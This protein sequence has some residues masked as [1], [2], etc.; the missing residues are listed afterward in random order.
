MTSINRAGATFACD[1]I[2]SIFG[3]NHFT[4]DITADCIS[5]NHSLD[6]LSR[7][8]KSLIDPSEK[9]LP[10]ARYFAA[11]KYLLVTSST[12]SRW[13]RASGEILSGYIIHAVRDIVCTFLS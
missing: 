6:L 9:D 7:G 10:I 2:V 5:D 4:A 3:F 1:E 12:K 11:A 8:D 13:C